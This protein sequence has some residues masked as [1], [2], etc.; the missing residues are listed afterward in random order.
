MKM[1]I[2]KKILVPV[3][4]SVLLHISCQ[5]V[6]EQESLIYI[7]NTNPI[8]DDRSAEAAVNGMYDALQSGQLYG[9]DFI[10]A[11]ELTAGN[12]KAAGFSIQWRELESAI[13]PSAN[14]HVE[15]NWVDFYLGIN[16]ANSIISSVPAVSGISDGDKNYYMG[17]AYFVRGLSYFDLLRQYGEFDTPESEYG[18]PLSIEPILSPTKLARSTVA[19]SYSR[20][21]EDLSAAEKL[22]TY[23]GTRSYATK[24]AVEALLARVHLYRGNYGD[25]FSYADKV[26]KNSGY[27][28]LENYNDLYVV[29]GNN[30]SIL[31]LEF[32]EQDQNSFN[33]N[34]L[35]SPPEVAVSEDL[36]NSFGN[37]D[38]RAALFSQGSDGNI[39]CLKYGTSPNLGSSNV[40][41]LRLAEMYLIRAEG[42]A[43]NNEPGKAIDDINAVR[44]RAG[45][46]LLSEEDFSNTDDLLEAVMMEKR[47]E[48]AFENGSYW[49]DV[50]RL[51]RLQELRGVEN[52]R[53]I[54]PIPNRER[55]ADSALKQNPGYEQ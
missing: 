21:L 49:F 45:A 48:F 37:T 27:Q 31:E 43:R 16:T 4:L 54:Y 35:T 55:L 47:L 3:I 25:A 53:R 8:N 50:A 18:V 9:S 52:F 41:I 34:M 32:S 10:L 28:L 42:Y 30:E 51:G 11:N 29:K 26:I 23:G 6:L 33:I 12:A 22:L 24:A 20:I 17:Q 46:T 38:N 1:N 7:E 19:E 13:I 14:F 2:F 40:I 15:D 39:K 44:D 5:D 36:Y